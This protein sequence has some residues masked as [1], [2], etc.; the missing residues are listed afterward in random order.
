MLAGACS[1]YVQM[2]YLSFMISSTPSALLARV[3]FL[4]VWTSLNLVQLDLPAMKAN[5]AA[6]KSKNLAQSIKDVQKPRETILPILSK[7]PVVACA[8]ESTKTGCLAVKTDQ[9]SFIFFSI[10]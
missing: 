4:L 2:H 3:L 7:K 8:E 1:S 6:P 10:L 9:G 5:T